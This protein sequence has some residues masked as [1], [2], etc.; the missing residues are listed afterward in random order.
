ML[1]EIIQISHLLTAGQY[2]KNSAFPNVIINEWNKLD[3]KDYK[4][5]IT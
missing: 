3:I 4:Y 2:F 5:K 1:I